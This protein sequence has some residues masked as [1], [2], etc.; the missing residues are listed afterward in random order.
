MFSVCQIYF[1][2]TL[3]TLD[4]NVYTLDILATNS[5]RETYGGHHGKSIGEGNES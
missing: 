4:I 5:Q 2:I 3:D 1:S